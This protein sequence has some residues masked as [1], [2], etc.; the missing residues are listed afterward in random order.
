[1]RI[2]PKEDA[3][4]KPENNDD[5][6]LDPGPYTVAMVFFKRMTSNAGNDYLRGKF[7]VVSG[8]HKGAAFWASIGLSDTDGAKSRLRLYLRC[9]GHEHPVETDDDASMYDAFVGRAFRVKLKKEEY[10]GK[11]RNDIRYYE[12]GPVSD[13]ERALMN[14]WEAEYWNGKPMSKPGA[15]LPQG[16]NPSDIPAAE[17]V[18]DDDIPF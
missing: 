15:R 6:V 3:P 5:V 1:M 12:P 2:D 10:Q 18:Y 9:V 7:E 4:T 11:W 14:R 16:Q 17:D 8:E 13:E